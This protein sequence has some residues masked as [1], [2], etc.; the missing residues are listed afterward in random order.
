VYLNYSVN[1]KFKVLQ[2]THFIFPILLVMAIFILDLAIEMPFFLHERVSRSN[3]KITGMY[4]KKTNFPFSLF[5][6]EN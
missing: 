5:Q 1:E 2:A 6:N 4:K 3:V